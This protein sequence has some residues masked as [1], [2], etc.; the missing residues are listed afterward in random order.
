MAKERIRVVDLNNFI[1]KSEIRALIERWGK[2]RAEELK[3]KNYD[4]DETML[5]MINQLKRLLMEE[6]EDGKT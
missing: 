5:T 3:R 1:H 2:C 6:T 4:A